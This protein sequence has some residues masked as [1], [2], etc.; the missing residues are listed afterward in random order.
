MKKQLLTIVFFCLSVSLFGA[1]KKVGTLVRDTINDVPCV[2][3]LPS[4]YATRVAEQGSPY[5]CLYL[6]HGMFGSENDWANHGLIAIMDSLL[7]E[8]VVVEMVIVMPDN[9]L[10]SIPT[11][12]RLEFMNSPA[13]KPNGQ[14]F[15]LTD[16]VGHWRRLTA[17]QERAYEQSGYWEEHFDAFIDAV[18]RK[19]YL[20]P[21]SKNRAI[22]GLSMGGFHSLHVNQFL[23]GAFDYVGLFSP[24]VLP[25][26]A[27]KALYDAHVEGFDAQ[28]TYSSEVYSHWMDNLRSQAA[29]PP[30]LWIGMGRKDSLYGQ[31]QQFRKWLEANDYEYT[32]FESPGG[33]SW[34]NWTDYLQRFLK[35]CFLREY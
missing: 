6:Q 27:Y 32:Y 7:K 8:E 18:E 25:R 13:V 2:V 23:T 5:P 14:P 1:A 19:Y 35:V 31:L 11:A 20:S 22:A 9:F 10:G 24:V 21:R 34:T 26:P 3:Y 16:G 33:H 17:E 29:L 4:S 15:D 12:K 28:L 30:A